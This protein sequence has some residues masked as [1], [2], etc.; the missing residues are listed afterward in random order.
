MRSWKRKLYD[1]YQSHRCQALKLTPFE[2]VEQKGPFYKNIIKRHLP[3]EKNIRIL[4]LGCGSGAFLYWAARAGYACGTGVDGSEEQIARARVLGISQIVQGDVFDYLNMLPASSQDVVVAFDV[5]EHL[6]RDQVFPFFEN[7]VRVLSKNGRLIIHT[8]NGESPFVGRMLFGDLTHEQAFTRFS[9]GQLAAA[10][11]FADIHF[12][13]DSPIPDSFKN[14]I[15]A[16]LWKAIRAV[17][18]VA[19]YI[20]TGYLARGNI[21]S[22][23]IMAV[24]EASST[25]P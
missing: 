9:L 17:F 10:A 23:N 1:H 13:E 16:L 5:L 4:D 19:V 14:C 18:I 22:Q 11:G 12:F 20:E 3:G 7:C 21:Y 24:A 2:E 25:I 15:R 8:L 6:S